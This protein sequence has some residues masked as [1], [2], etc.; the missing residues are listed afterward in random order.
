MEKPQAWLSHKAVV[1]VSNTVKVGI[2]EC[3]SEGTI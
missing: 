3:F 1:R 2:S